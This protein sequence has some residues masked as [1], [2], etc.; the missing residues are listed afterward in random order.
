MKVKPS[1]KK[2]IYNPKTLEEVVIA[3]TKMASDVVGSTLGPYGRVVLIERGERLPPYTTKDGITVFQNLALPGSASQVVLEALRDSS[4]KT[5]V[6]AGDGTTTATILAHFI[7]AEGFKLLKNRRLSA[8]QIMREIEFA[9]NKYI[10]PFI[11]KN[12]LK[13]S[14]NW[15]DSYSILK[16]VAI[17]ATNSDHDMAEAVLEC[18]K[19]VGYDGH[20]N[21]VE[22]SG[23]SGYEVERIEG[24]PIARGF[25]ESCGRYSEEFIN[26]RSNYRVV[27]ERPRFILYNGKITS[28]SSIMPAIESISQAFEQAA[29]NNDKTFSP[30][31][32]LVAHSFSD[33]VLAA[34]AYNFKN[35]TSLNIYPLKTVMTAQ[36]N[37]PY[38]FLLDLAAFTGAMIFDPISRP[39][40]TLKVTDLGI[41]SMNVFES[42]RYRSVVLGEPDEAIV[43]MRAEEL[44][45][46]AANASS[47]LDAELT[48]ERLGILTGGIARLKIK[49]SSEAEL[50]EKK[51]RVEDAVLAIKGALKWGVLPGGGKT[52]LAL[53]NYLN[54]VTDI[55]PEVKNILCK[56]FIEPFYRIYQNG[57]FNDSQIYEKK[58]KIMYNVTNKFIGLVNKFC[59]KYLKIDLIKKMYNPTE[60][61]YTHNALTN[62]Y[63][64]G[65]EIGVV[66]SAA[67]VLLS[68]KNAISVAKMLMG[69]S[70]VIAYQ[71]DISL[72][73]EAAIQGLVDEREQQVAMQQYEDEQ[74]NFWKYM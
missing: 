13:V 35:P 18:F 30:N 29:Q 7:I 66:D 41:S 25:E 45:H 5:N 39:L 4:S 26:D 32:I 56:S 64:I 17:I 11:S 14:P 70:A 71:R 10:E 72:E 54:Q 48:K 40:S 22:V 73:R 1:I 16:Q 33:E 50:K 31:F 60:F 44:M 38:H 8:Q 15:S 34:L 58:V 23:V 42:Y 36:S 57:G 68:I 24:F 74:N 55:M 6:E 49:G 67:A 46:Q 19:I 69:L 43:T 59:S 2:T 21:I 47:T 65:Y 63:G 20:V 52:L 28:L 3:T 27:L 62:Q 61:W 51:H 12:A 53:S 9:Y 37:S